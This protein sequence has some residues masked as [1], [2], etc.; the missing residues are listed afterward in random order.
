MDPYTP[1][2]GDCPESPDKYIRESMDIFVHYGVRGG[3]RDLVEGVEELFQSNVFAVTF[4]A[5]PALLSK[6]CI[7]RK[8]FV[9]KTLFKG[10]D[11]LD[12]LGDG[13]DFTSYRGDARTREL[14]SSVLEGVIADALPAKRHGENLSVH[15]GEG[16]A[17][18]KK[19]DAF[20][21]VTR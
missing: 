13:W 20:V 3:I 12:I 14:K 8:A 4:Q 9:R 17:H 15:R 18:V 1:S 6:H 21:S 2:V 19:E 5:F 7:A 10:F 11:A 16:T